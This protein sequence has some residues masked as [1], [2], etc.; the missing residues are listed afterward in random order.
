MILSLNVSFE[1]RGGT[2]R[3]WGDQVPLWVGSG[4][5]VVGKPATT[6]SLPPTTYH[7]PIRA[8][9]G[10]VILS[11]QGQFSASPSAGSGQARG[12][13]LAGQAELKKLELEWR[14]GAAL[15]A[16]ETGGRRGPPL[17]QP[18]GGGVSL[19]GTVPFAFEDGL[20]KVPELSLTVGD[21]AHI[22][23]AATLPLDGKAGRVR[24]LK[25]LLPPTKISSL[26]KAILGL[27]PSML[28]D[29]NLQGALEA[30]VEILGDQ[31]QGEVRIQEMGINGGILNMA[32]ASGRIPLLGNFKFEISDF[33]KVPGEGWL[34]LSEQVFKNEMLRFAQQAVSQ[35]PASS[36]PSLTISSVSFAGLTLRDLAVHFS[37]R[38]GPLVIDHL[39]FQGLGGSGRGR[40]LLD[41]FGGS[42]R[43]MLLVEGL[44]LREICDQFPPIKGY[45][46]GKV[47]G[48][49][50]LSLPLFEPSQAKGRARFW[51]VKS[52]EEPRKIS[53]ALIERLGG[54]SGGFFNLLALRGDRSYNHG[55]LEVALEDRSLTFHR[56]E[57]SNT[58]LFIKDLDIKVVPPYNTIA[59]QDLFDTIQETWE[60]VQG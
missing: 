32:G 33:K 28:L 2:F 37:T 15:P 31:V 47:N 60:R 57:I 14:R 34:E 42:L 13:R 38:N 9:G 17:Q 48:M 20:L 36:S 26:Q 46:S 10:E 16:P 54:Q 53:K 59:I 52:K 45:I 30:K 12:F 24:S 4:L 6:Y 35:P 50:E 22:V 27:L 5:W 11:W 58:I 40:G 7:L 8:R 25:L 29:A 3:F 19:S 56:L 49:L 23:F 44:S 41:L 39:S 43:L 21:E 18:S 51:A 1:Y 55:L